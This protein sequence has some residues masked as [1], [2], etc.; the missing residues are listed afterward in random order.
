[1]D[2]LASPVRPLISKKFGDL[3]TVR[4]WGLFFV[5]LSYSGESINPITGK[6]PTSH[7]NPNTVRKATGLEFGTSA[8]TTPNP[9]VCMVTTEKASPP[10]R[11]PRNLGGD[12]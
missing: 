8:R 6:A 5:R 3:R 12:I 7:C 1:M 11:M 4:Y 2:F 9:T 10:S